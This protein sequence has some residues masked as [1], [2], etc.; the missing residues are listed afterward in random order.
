MLRMHEW[1]F[2]HAT[3]FLNIPLEGDEISLFSIED[4]VVFAFTFDQ[5]KH[6]LSQKLDALEKTFYLSFFRAN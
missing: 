3:N 5:K 2:I 1:F 6:L 4:N